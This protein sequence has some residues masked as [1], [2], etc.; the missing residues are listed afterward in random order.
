MHKS[1]EHEQHTY[2]YASF[3][4]ALECAFGGLLSTKDLEDCRLWS[5]SKRIG[6]EMGTEAE[7]WRLRMKILSILTAVM[8]P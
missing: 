7:R 8:D 3:L 4:D 6:D 2:S 1:L 5:F